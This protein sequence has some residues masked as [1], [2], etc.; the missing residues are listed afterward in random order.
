MTVAAIDDSLIGTT[1]AGRYEVIREIG[2]GGMGAI[3]EVRHKKLKRL[4]AMKVLSAK[5]QRNSEALT[6]F[7]REA[8]IIA[9][10]RHPNVVEVIDI[11]S[12]ADDSPCMIMELLTGEDLAT[13]I[14]R[15]GPLPWSMLAQIADQVLSALAAAHQNGIVH[16]DLKPQNVFLK[17]EETG[18]EIPKLLDF[19]VSKIQSA[20]SMTLTNADQLIGTPAY[21]S[22]EQADGRVAEVGPATDVWAMGAI[23]FEM[24]T[25]RRA[26]DAPS[27]M[28]TLYR[29]CHESPES[30]EK[31]R[32]DAPRAFIDLVGQVLSR[33][34][35][36]RLGD[37]LTLR[38]QLRTALAEFSSFAAPMS[39]PRIVVPALETAA[40]ELDLPLSAL[41]AKF[42][43]RLRVT[44]SHGW[45]TGALAA[46]V[47]VVAGLTLFFA[48]RHG[49]STN[50][51]VPRANAQ[52]VI[53][54]GGQPS[55]STVPAA[56]PSAAENVA[57]EA[58]P[59][60]TAEVVEPERKPEPRVKVKDHSSRAKK[61]T[62]AASSAVDS[63][64]VHTPAVVAPAPQPEGRKR[65]EWEDK[66]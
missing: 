10:L 64:T 1:V 7:Q 23:L 29:I 50:P 52:M 17:R 62:P 19:G 35:A 55:P 41:S 6:R 39:D 48:T 8:D 3:Y 25:G 44:R 22:P 56:A 54:A 32:P 14:K 15:S 42:G 13:R 30:L 18:Q 24:S 5:L 16:R 45:R 66:L 20:E 43:D 65:G 9:K 49:T 28:S 38:T 33:D 11:D 12:L 40:T 57:P 21:M 53:P 27:T 36:I 47:M 2:K 34:A 46:A 59:R 26:F 37:V 61:T 51:N 63:A 58:A 60:T 31:H 4:F